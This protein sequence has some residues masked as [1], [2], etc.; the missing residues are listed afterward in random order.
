MTVDPQTLDNL[1][2]TGGIAAGLYLLNR[3]GRYLYT[4][5][6]L[7]D[8]KDLEELAKMARGDILFPV[9]RD[10]NI[11]YWTEQCTINQIMGYLEKPLTKAH[12]NKLKSGYA[13]Q[14][15]RLN[16]KVLQED[17]ASLQR[18]KFRDFRDDEIPF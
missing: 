6:K 9:R 11:G 1:L 2:A 4:F 14:L 8:D 12:F 3:A 15:R 18:G 5:F 16:K 7:A 13:K 17:L 10:T